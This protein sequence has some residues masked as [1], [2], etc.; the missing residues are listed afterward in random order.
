MTENSI[1]RGQPIHHFAH[2]YDQCRFA[3]T[4]TPWGCWDIRDRAVR[5]GR[6]NTHP[7]ESSR[8]AAACRLLSAIVSACGAL[9]NATSPELR[10]SRASWPA[11]GTCSGLLGWMKRTKFRLSASHWHADGTCTQ[12][13]DDHA[14]KLQAS[15]DSP[16]GARLPEISSAAAHGQGRRGSLRCNKHLCCFWRAMLRVGRFVQERTRIRRPCQEKE[17][18]DSRSS[19]ARRSA[20]ASRAAAVELMSERR[21]SRHEQLA[22]GTRVEARRTSSLDHSDRLCVLPFTRRLPASLQSACLLRVDCWAVSSFEVRRG[23]QSTALTLS[24]DGGPPSLAHR[25]Y[26]G[27]IDERLANGRYVVSFPDGF[28]DRGVPREWLRRAS[29]SGGRNTIVHLKCQTS[30][31]EGRVRHSF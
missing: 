6:I 9:L 24:L 13:S 31:Q 3:S 2:E 1:A 23:A 14:F 8:P 16:G 17:Q 7:A 12:Q 5:C 10:E 18:A 11:L 21:S 22:V 30:S 26:A 29:L 20:L 15:C 25:L 4:A 27:V 28:V 19:A